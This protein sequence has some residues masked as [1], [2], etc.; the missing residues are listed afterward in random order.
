M[1]NVIQ[2]E[3]LFNIKNWAYVMAK[4]SEIKEANKRKSENEGHRLDRVVRRNLKIM[5][6]INPGLFTAA[7]ARGM[8]DDD[9]PDDDGPD[10][11]ESLPVGSLSLVA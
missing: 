6:D 8:D 5:A 11:G 2:A 10:P 4:A 3:D 7:F 9:D 1:S